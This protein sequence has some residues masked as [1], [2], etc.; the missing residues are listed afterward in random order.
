[1]QRL[2][3]ANLHYLKQA[4]A[5]LARL[6]D[7]CYAKP[8]PSFYNSSVGGH[9]RHCLEHYLSFLEGVESGRV[10]YDHRERNQSVEAETGCACGEVLNISQRLESLLESENPV[11]LLVKMDCGGE[12]IE[13]QPST[14]GRELQFLVS[15][16]VHHFAMIGGIC[17]SMELELESDFG[18]APSTVRHRAEVEAS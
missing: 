8:A 13:W 12:D 4:E 6:D 11:G 17:K 9:L 7:D 18:V 5:L 2:I 1:M 10:D 16:T 14:V 3:H 15:H